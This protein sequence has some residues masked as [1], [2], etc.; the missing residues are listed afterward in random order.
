MYF[1]FDWRCINKKSMNHS[2]YY[3]PLLLTIPRVTSLVIFFSSPRV[4]ARL[5]K[6]S[7][8]FG[9]GCTAVS[10]HEF[11]CCH[12]CKGKGLYWNM[13][14]HLPQAMEK[15]LE[16]NWNPRKIIKTKRK[17]FPST[18]WIGI[19]PVMNFFANPWIFF[20]YIFC[21]WNIGWFGLIERDLSWYFPL[22]WNHHLRVKNYS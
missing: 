12:R 22:V 11:L 21:G 13:R 18:G 1:F 14:F 10:C 6:T 20:A 16:E 8:F 3:Y 9:G 19:H 17:D 5:R 7:P 4:F 15:M 2:R